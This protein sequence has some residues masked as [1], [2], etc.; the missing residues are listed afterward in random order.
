[1]SQKA[2]LIEE[3]Y[4]SNENLWP[5]HDVMVV[6]GQVVGVIKLKSGQDKPIEES[7]D[8]SYWKIFKKYGFFRVLMTGVILMFLDSKVSKSELYV[9]YIAVSSK[10][11]GK[12]YGSK[13]LD[14]GEAFAR[15]MN[16]IDKYTLHVIEIN[17][18]ARALYERYGFVVVS[19]RRGGLI[20]SLMGINRYHHMEKEL[21]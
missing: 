19:T 15:Q 10:A 21:N 3:A 5:V 1:M 8:I 6:D 16:G 18:K 4:L 7:R 2:G 17:S 9:D 20:G 13:L 12:G 14:Y 11:R